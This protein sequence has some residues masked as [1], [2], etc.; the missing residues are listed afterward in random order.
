MVQNLTIDAKEHNLAQA[1]AEPV[2]LRFKSAELRRLFKMNGQDVT[3]RDEAN[4]KDFAALA[5]N[6]GASA[7]HT[8][9]TNQRKE[10]EKAAYLKRV[11]SGNAMAKTLGAPLETYGN[12]FLENIT[13]GDTEINDQGLLMVRGGGPNSELREATLDE[14]A[15]LEHNSQ[16]CSIADTA[17]EREMSAYFG[18]GTDTIPESLQRLADEKRLS[19]PTQDELATLVKER[20]ADHPHIAQRIVNGEVL[21]LQ[22]L[23]GPDLLADI[24]ITPR[25]G[26]SAE[27]A[28]F[29]DKNLQEMFFG[30]TN[31]EAM[32]PAPEK[33]PSLT[34]T[35]SA[36]TPVG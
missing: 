25:V 34:P 11:H 5:G 2:E 16:Q 13:L 20:Y 4:E 23:S 26:T 6:D 31:P 3:G 1:R 19:N 17:E 9:I 35:I 36:P 18:G 33:L 28:E 7:A 10:E 15:Q 30:A 21:D 24:G 8:H 32:T 27:P 29:A 22:N 12:K 14:K